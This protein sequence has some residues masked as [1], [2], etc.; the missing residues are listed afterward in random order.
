[1]AITIITGLPGFGKTSKLCEFAYKSMMTGKNVYTNFNMKNLPSNI[2][3]LYHHFKE[4]LEV[5]G[6]V[7]NAN[8]YISEVGIQMSDYVMHEL[9][10]S[11]WEDLS[12]HRHDGV[13]IV[14]DAQKKSQVAWRFWNLIQ[15]QFHIYTSFKITKNR[16]IG[17][18]RCFDPQPKGS[19]YGRRY[20]LS[21]PFY[22]NF[23]DTHYKLEKTSSLFDIGQEQIIAPWL[24]YEQERY[25]ELLKQTKNLPEGR[26]NA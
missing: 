11:V 24:D 4:P 20:W 17:F 15:Y 5:L 1:L 26:L 10:N 19:D 21:N 3:H 7:Q 14:C 2:Q 18:V 8:I 25:I 16:R 13:N 23:Y 9:P 22:F 6:R 12:Q